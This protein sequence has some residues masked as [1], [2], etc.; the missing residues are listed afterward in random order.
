MVLFLVIV[1]VWFF[2]GDNNIFMQIGFVVLI[3]LVVKN[4][5]LIVEF[6]CVKES[7]GV[8]LLVVVFEVV[9]LWLCLILM[10]L[11]V[12]I[13]GVVLLVL[14][15]GVGVEMCYVMGIVVFVGMLGVMVFGLVLMLVFYVVVCKLVLCCEVCYVCVGM[16]DQY[17]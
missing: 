9:C 17:V 7:E 12:F 14:V 5:I 16:I 13:V 1:G 6:V 11:F 4:V 3:G 10:M 2:G 8:D 15:S